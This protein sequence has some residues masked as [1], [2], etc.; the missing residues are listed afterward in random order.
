MGGVSTYEQI[1]E[2]LGRRPFVPFR[3]VLRNGETVDVVR[4]AQA[5]T[6]KRRVRV[7]T[8]SGAGASR[9]IWHEQIDH[10]ET[11]GAPQA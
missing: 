9:W 8:A 7:G 3:L 2:H 6:M 10:V 4:M 1:R 11:A 5:A